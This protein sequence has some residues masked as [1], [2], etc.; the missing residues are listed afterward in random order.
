M[1]NLQENDIIKL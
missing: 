1:L